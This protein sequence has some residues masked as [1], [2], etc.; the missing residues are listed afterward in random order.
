M[1]SETS[2]FFKYYV[3]KVTELVWLSLVQSP[4]VTHHCFAYRTTYTT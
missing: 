3:I 1:T 4:F 2:L